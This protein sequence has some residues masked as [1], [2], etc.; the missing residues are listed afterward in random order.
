MVCDRTTS[1]QSRAEVRSDTETHHFKDRSRVKVGEG[2]CNSLKEKSIWRQKQAAHLLIPSVMGIL[3]GAVLAYSSPASAPRPPRSS[4]SPPPSSLP[5]PSLSWLSPQMAT[6][7]KTS[8]SA[9]PRPVPFSL[10]HPPAPRS[11]SCC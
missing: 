1:H 2:A 3:T 11:W 8:N 9:L 10:G 5:S 6:G 4:S 7:V